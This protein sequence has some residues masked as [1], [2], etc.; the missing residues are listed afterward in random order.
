MLL[1]RSNIITFKR[2][3]TKILMTKKSLTS[4]LCLFVNEHDLSSAITLLNSITKDWLGKIENQYSSR[5]IHHL[6]TDLF[7]YFNSFT[8]I[9][10][11]IENQH[12]IKC[13][14]RI[15]F[16]AGVG[17]RRK[18]YRQE[19]CGRKTSCSCVTDPKD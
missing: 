8:L 2:F 11:L 17:R 9:L 16:E 14:F 1:Y 12:N 15:D 5:E 18:E 4:S 7:A 3:L 19:V 10:D 13:F 6:E